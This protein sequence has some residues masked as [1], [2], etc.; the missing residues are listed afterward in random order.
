MT[1]SLNLLTK[2]GEE[3]KG[4]MKVESGQRQGEGIGEGEGEEGGDEGDI[5]MDV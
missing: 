1:T 3:K 2:S 4:K 5:E